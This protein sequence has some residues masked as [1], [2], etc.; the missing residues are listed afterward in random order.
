M[1]RGP[2]VITRTSTPCPYTTLFRSGRQGEAA[3]GEIREQRLDVAQR[4]LAG[5]RIAVVTDGGV[6]GEARHDA[7]GGEDIAD[8]AKVAVSVEVLPVEGDDA[9]RFL[10]PV[11][12]GVQAERGQRG[13]ILV[14]EHAEDPALVVELVVVARSLAIPR[15]IASEGGRSD[16]HT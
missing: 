9:G 10:T 11:L 12:Q 8:Q 1:M 3:A 16:G 14:A 6:A 7:F 5:G 15:P 13:G 2:P 4:R